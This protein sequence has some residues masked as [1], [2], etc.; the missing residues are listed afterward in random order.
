LTIFRC[1]MN[2]NHQ[3]KE[4]IKSRI[5]A[6]IVWGIIGVVL[7]Y[8]LT[9]IVALLMLSGAFENKYSKSD[10]ISNYESN[11]SQIQEL[12]SYV[13]KIVPKD[14]KVEIEFEDSNTL[15][16]FHVYVG[17]GGDR[18]WGLETDSEETQR[19]LNKLGW[20]CAILDT[21]KMKLDNANCISIKSGEPQTIGYQRSGMGKYFYKLFD[22]ELTAEEIKKYND[23]CTYIYYKP[24]IVLEFGG[25]AIGQQCFAASEL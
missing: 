24:N 8:F 6:W 19:L 7:I 12:A 21:L 23:S 18:N 3:I 17:G 14:V 5:V 13:K 10:L 11:S 22:H 15:T 25:G 4:P 1:L 2:G 16:Y 20:N 9:T